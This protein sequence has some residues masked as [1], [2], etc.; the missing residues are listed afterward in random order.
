MICDAVL[1]KYVCFNYLDA[2]MLSACVTQRLH[3]NVL[4]TYGASQ[5][6]SLHVVVSLGLI[7]LGMQRA[8]FHQMCKVN[9]V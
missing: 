3:R 1:I 9:H 7:N 4:F 5:T 8:P 6:P 2:C